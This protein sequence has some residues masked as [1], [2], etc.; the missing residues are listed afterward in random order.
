VVAALVLTPLVPVSNLLKH[1]S[2]G[3][4]GGAGSASF[5]LTTVNPFIRLRRD[6]VEKTHTPLLYAETKSASTS[7]V[8]TTVLDQFTS[9]EWRPSPRTLPSDNNASG[10][11]PS[12]PGLAAGIA[13]QTDNWKL[14]LAS[15][16]STSWLPLPY[17]IL[18][19]KIAGD[20]WRFDSRTL[21]VAN[22]NGAAT[23]PL[24][25]SVTAFTPDLSQSALR[26]SLHAPLSIR[27][28]MT[29]LP[30]DFPD[31]IRTQAEKV[32]KGA[33]SDF[34]KA[35]ALQDWFRTGGGFTYSLD[36][37]GGSGMDL[38]AHF[39][40]D[41]RV[42]YCEQ[43]ASAM[44]AMGRALGIPSRVVVGFLD[45]QPLPDG[46]ILYTSDERHAWP[47]MYFPGS[48][49]VR[50]EPTPAQRAA[51]VPAYTQSRSATQAPTQAP[52][53]TPSKLPNAKHEVV[54]QDVTTK[55]SSSFSVPWQLVAAVLVLA[56]LLIGPGALRLMQRRRRLR[57]Q[58]PVHLAEGAWAELG[59]TALDLGLDWPEHRSPREQA[60]R[61]TAQV[62]AGPEEVAALEGLLGE[63][64]RGRYAPPVT[65]AS[66]EP[67]DRS[68]TVQTL[69][70]WRHA[71]GASVQHPWRARLWPRSLWRRG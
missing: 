12:A 58:D 10:D 8:R 70:S 64:E 11:F 53:S 44:A 65:L 50:F 46:R 59:A 24:N 23:T 61:V 66:I 68:R 27:E 55:D 35:V 29:K 34:D 32:T 30:Q 71:M 60:G 26:T 39:V 67:D 3:G 38:L 22:I 2:G 56:L 20:S 13:G 19:L 33:K 49:W 47:E 17:P 62:P 51:Y 28:P 5:Q 1:G 45:G 31:V 40:T 7:Y 6:L 43:F 69:D 14:S 36:Q 63:V 54:P 15:S 21:D 57:S 37:R 16:F 18:Q 25:Y 52:T 9:N 41:D 4:T 42:G 48:G